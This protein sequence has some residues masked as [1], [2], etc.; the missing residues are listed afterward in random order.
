[1]VYSVKSNFSVIT[2]DNL[3]IIKNELL[4]FE[5]D[6]YHSIEWLLLN[7]DN[8]AADEILMLQGAKE[9]ETVA[10][11]MYNISGHNEIWNTCVISLRKGRKSDGTESYRKFRQD[12]QGIF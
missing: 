7:K 4:S 8:Q 10:E 3:P 9:S 2:E 6:I 5:T 1:M 11:I 12:H